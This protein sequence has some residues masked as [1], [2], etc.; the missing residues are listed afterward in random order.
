M[1]VAENLNAA[2][3][4][5]LDDDPTAYMI[6]E[7]ILDPYGGAFKVTKGLSTR[8]PGRVIGTPISEGALT[9]VAA[10]LALT[11][12]TAVAEIMFGDFVALAFDQLC[13]FASKSVSM[14]G[15]RLPLRMV[16]RCPTGGG[17][18][19]GPTHSQSLQKHF[20]GMPGL[21]LYEMSPFHD[22]RAVLG[23]MLERGEPCVF[24]EDKVLYT[25]QMDQVDPLFTVRREGGLAVVDL[26]GPDAR[27]DCVIIAPGGMAH[28][29]L[30]AMRSL[31]V[32]QEIS[33][34][35]LVPSRLYPLDADALLP[36]LGEVV[37]VAEESTAGG[38][39]GSEVAH[40]LHARLWGRLRGPVRLVH[41][42]ASVIPTAAHL[43]NEVLVGESTIHHA[44]REALRG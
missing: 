23:A 12:N 40:L 1:R 27:P 41:S 13:N 6:G 35:L 9:G 34:R 10:G 42:R 15:R 4:G 19:Y 37:L 44:V 39:W 36:F 21:S 2:L 14:Y 33:G 8:F 3:H 43:E 25:R 17:R 18:G 16:V 20:V 32:E 7:D 11:G 24:F 26:R 29:A 5:L 28:R 31:L 30:A 38:T 22:N